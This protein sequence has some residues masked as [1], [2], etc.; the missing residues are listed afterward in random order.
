MQYAGTK[1]LAED[2]LG[3]EGEFTTWEVNYCEND[4][5]LNS[6]DYRVKVKATSSEYVHLWL[7]KSGDTFTI[8]CAKDGKGLFD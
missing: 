4:N 2:S 7:E 8:R 1:E 5:S 3:R 6:V